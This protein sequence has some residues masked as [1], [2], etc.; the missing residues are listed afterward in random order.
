MFLQSCMA[1]LERPGLSCRYL[2]HHELGSV[3]I[4]IVTMMIIIIIIIIIIFLTTV[5]IIITI[6][7][8]I[9]PSL[10]V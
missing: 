10:L 5:I 3:F 4:F 1:A 8:I 7:I 9:V 6:I 2:A